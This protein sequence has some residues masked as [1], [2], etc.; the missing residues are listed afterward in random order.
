MKPF[1]F[2]VAGVCLTCYPQFAD[3]ER[4]FFRFPVSARQTELVAQQPVLVDEAHWSEVASIWKQR[5]A[6]AE[7]S[8]LSFSCSDALLP[9]DRLVIHACALRCQDRAWLILAPTGVGKTTQARWLHVLC[10]GDFSVISGD[11]PVLEFQPDRIVVHPSPWNGKEDWHGAQAAPLAGFILLARGP[12]NAI[13]PLSDQQTAVSI[14]GNFLSA[15]WSEARIHCI[16]G[17]ATRLIRAVPKWL[18]TTCQVPDSTKLLLQTVFP[19]LTP[20]PDDP[21]PNPKSFP[22]KQDVYEV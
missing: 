14:L 5:S 8:E 12:E 11:R 16:A 6:E 17:F 13:R 7:F 15:D 1:Q 21:M 10:P 9:F 2:S 22:R 3:T 20:H 18:L 4:F 19:F